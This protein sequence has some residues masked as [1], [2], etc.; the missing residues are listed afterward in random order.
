MITVTMML[1]IMHMVNTQHVQG[2]AGSP[3][4]VKG[5]EPNKPEA[6]CMYSRWSSKT[7]SISVRDKSSTASQKWKLRARQ[8][9]LPEKDGKRQ[10]AASWQRRF[11]S[12]LSLP[13]QPAVC[14]DTTK[15]SKFRKGILLEHIWLHHR[16]EKFVLDCIAEFGKP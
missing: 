9:T 13:A 14:L 8:A 7:R 4:S 6:L 5:T 16:N 11:S 2:K 15:L 1:M 3:D 10:E 12:P